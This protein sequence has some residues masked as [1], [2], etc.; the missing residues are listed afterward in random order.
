MLL[1]CGRGVRTTRVSRSPKNEA[2]SK[3]RLKRRSRHSGRRQIELA[4]VQEI[5]FQLV[6]ARQR[7]KGR[8][9][10]PRSG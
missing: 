4:I 3:E 9:M 6:F 1:A 2:E 7:A 8:K 10:N 5:Y